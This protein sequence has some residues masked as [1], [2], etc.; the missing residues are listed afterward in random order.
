MK[1]L[2]MT[3]LLLSCAAFGQQF[4]GYAGGWVY[5]APPYQ[6]CVGDTQNNGCFAKNA[7]GVTFNG[8]GAGSGAFN[9]NGALSA[10][11]NKFTVNSSGLVTTDNN[12]TTAGQGNP[13]ILG[14]T[15][16]KAE[17]NAADTNVLTVT[18]AAAAGTYKVSF[19]CSVSSA[20]SGIISWTLSYKD[21]NANTQSN[22]AQ[23]LFQMGTAA[24]NTTF[25]TSAAGN[26][27]G[28]VLIDT[29][30]SATA[31]VVKWVGGGTS[32]ALVS[33]TIERVI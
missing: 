4:S 29:D 8:I 14:A 32:A 5:V 33:A 22:V 12:L 1:R 23:Q 25:T 16:Q 28:S 3:M 19:V 10:A 27:Y 26:Y 30:N 17:T 6:L 24:P 7:N 11:T 15:S 21:S 9:F 20:T 18:P 31:I 13:I 2:L